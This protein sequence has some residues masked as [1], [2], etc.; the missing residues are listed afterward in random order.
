[1]EVTTAANGGTVTLDPGDS[2]E[3]ILHVYG[4]PTAGLRP[5]W[6]AV[7]FPSSVRRLR[8]EVAASTNVGLD[9]AGHAELTVDVQGEGQTS[10]VSLAP[11][12]VAD[13]TLSGVVAEIRPTKSD[14]AAARLGIGE[15]SISSGCLVDLGSI[16]TPKVTVDG[17]AT[18][19]SSDARIDLL[20]VTPGSNLAC[21]LGKPGVVGRLTMLQVESGKAADQFVLESNSTLTVGLCVDVAVRLEERASLRVDGE[22]AQLDVTGPGQLSLA[23]ADAVTFRSPPVTLN[24]DPHAQVVAATGTVRLGRVASSHIAGTGSAAGLSPGLT[25]ESVEASAD[26]LGNLSLVNATFPVSLSGRRTI[27]ALREHADNVTPMLTDNIPGRGP[28]RLPARAPRLIR[29]DLMMQSEF[30]RALAALAGERGAPASI[31]TDLAWSSYR[32][33][34]ASAPGR[35]ERWVLSA[36]RLIG[37]GERAI[38]PLVLYVGVAL[39]LAALSL[40]ERE[41]DPSL[42]GVA[43]YLGAFGNWL[44]TPLHLLRLTEDPPSA[45]TFSEPWGTL[46]R[47]A[48]AIPFVTAVL[49]FRNYVKEGHRPK[50]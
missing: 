6:M 49:A 27:S 37:Y 11:G 41:I 8:I 9:L 26:S 35:T 29:E 36:Y 40:H 17:T 4:N 12:S 15:L 32:M 46:A 21:V 5:P 14:V 18:L 16:D 39:V 22:C 24:L 34:N 1:M 42:G 19:R 10:S 23:A 30:T 25:V 2:G 50:A 20:N 7:R 3:A 38:P 28:W 44:I 33:R 47:I 43:T 45:Y 13:I 48:L 31:R